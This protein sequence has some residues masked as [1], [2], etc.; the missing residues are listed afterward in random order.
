MTF[1]QTQRLWLWAGALGLM[2]LAIIPL[3]TGIRVLAAASIVLVVALA[4]VRARRAAQRCSQ[5]LR[6]ADSMSLPPDDYRQPV[7]LVCGD[8]LE[9]LFGEF[10]DEQL[11][12]RT[13][14]QGCYL[15]VPSLDQLPTL[16]AA[17]MAERVHW[18]AQISVMLVINPGEHRDGAALAG[19]V[20]AFGYHVAKVRK[21]GL[22]LP[23]LLV[24]YV[25]SSQGEGPWFSWEGGRASPWVRE[26]AGCIDLV[27]WQRQA[28]DTKTQAA[29]MRTSVRLESVAAWLGEAVLAP[30]MTREARTVVG[31]PLACAITWVPVLPKAVTGNLWQQWLRE[32]I[33]L[34]D[35]RQVESGARGSLP[36]PDPLLTVLPT[37]TRRTPFSRSTVLALWLF[38]VAAIIALA[39]SAWQNTLL[40]RQVTDDLRRYS[41]IAESHG[42]DYSDFAHVEAAVA[43]LRQDAQRLDNYY[44][45]GEPLSLG[46]GLYRGEQLRAPLQATI[47][48][49]RP[50]PAPQPKGIASP[51]RLDS[52]SLFST[53]SAQLKPES[54]KVLINALVGIK[55][56]PGW[57]IVITGHT[58][59]TG[60]ADHNL[61]L[62][63]D[64][65]A[66]V[67]DWMQGMGDIPDSCFAVQGFGASQPIASNDTETGRTANRRVD[68]RLVPETG[69]CV[70]PVA[71]PDGQPPVASR[72]I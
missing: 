37:R 54:T 25:Q 41:A 51:V 33:A 14:A 43:V 57:L 32:K 40:V 65:A 11:V 52:L 2:L 28:M 48:N 69:A 34:S 58:D 3:A 39:S 66:A 12:L 24:S 31:P 20:R 44:R 10:A 5:P 56:Q 71:G 67:R 17:L 38:V 26:A 36:F 18:G 1:Q 70:F 68:I 9:G 29:R 13:T 60:N 45:W 23:L 49:H 7:V 72:G 50:P 15:R 16:A 22:A 19:Q 64:R 59:I 6:L 8:G 4:W 42:R 62:S 35:T 21:Q 30:L 27:D 46:L 53:G 61:Q 47:A 55:A 63:R